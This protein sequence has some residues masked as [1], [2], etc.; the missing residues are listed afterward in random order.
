M[1][2]NHALM[3][4]GQIIFGCVSGC[5]YPQRSN[6]WRVS[7]TSGDMDSTCDI[8]RLV[9][10]C[11]YPQRS[12]GWRV[13][14]TSGDM[15]STC[16]IPRLVSGC[17]YPQRSNGWTVSTTSGDMDSTCD[18]PRLVKSVSSFIIIRQPLCPVVGRRPQHVVSKLPCLVLSSAISC[19]SSICPG[20]LSTAGLVS[21]VVFSCHMVSKR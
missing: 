13:S 11:G 7:T 20:R 14:T 4:S 1:P 10:G 5:G 8:P 3:S 15:D 18:I 17:G 9:S 16:D 6:G 21:L 19:R 2:Q 12:N